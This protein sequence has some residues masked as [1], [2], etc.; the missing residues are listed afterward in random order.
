MRTMNDAG[1]QGL[2]RRLRREEQDLHDRL[3][4]HVSALDQAGRER[5]SNPLY[6]RLAGVFGTVRR[7]LANAERES[8]I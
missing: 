4:K 7:Q 1:H 6:Q 5:I 2:I 8:G 3:E